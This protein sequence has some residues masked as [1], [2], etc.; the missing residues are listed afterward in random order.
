M[1]GPA[2]QLASVPDARDT[3]QNIVYY[4]GRGFY[5]ELKF[6]GIRAVVEKDE[7]GNIRITNRK[8]ADITY[9]YPDVVAVFADIDFCGVLDGEI[10]VLNDKG[11]PDFAR[12]HL[13]DAQS[14]ERGVR[15]VAAAN[16]AKFIPFDALES[17]GEDLRPLPYLVRRQYLF[18]MLDAISDQVPISTTAGDALWTWVEQHDLEGLIAKDPQASYRAGERDASWVKLKNTKRIS[19]LVGGYSPGKGGRELGALY[20]MLWDPQ[21][22]A[23]VSIGSVGSG[24]NQ[25]QLVQLQA[26]VDS[27]DPVVV[28]VEYLDVS[29]GGQLRMP[30]FKA[31]R[32]DIDPGTCTIDT[33]V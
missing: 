2:V 4:M 28:E 22:G 1:S 30:V 33:L 14:S 12:V 26:D 13:R 27:G 21:A 31:I 10:I 17:K 8:Q 15:R 19:A 23:L 5:F 11:L 6:D 7:F 18:G 32:R 20:L 9:R 24:F 29:A 25:K 16:P 3:A